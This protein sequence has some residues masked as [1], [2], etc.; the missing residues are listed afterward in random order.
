MKAKDLNISS[1][2]KFVGRIPHEKMASLLAQ[3]DVY[4]STSLSDGTS[5]SLL[6]AMGS[7]AFPVVTDIPANREWIINGENG[8]L[9]STSDESILTRKI[10][11]AIRNRRLLKEASR[12]NL[13]IIEQRADWKTNIGKIT[14]IYE[15]FSTTG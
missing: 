11:E 10:L 1:V 6:E 3:A 13:K 4:V 12:K 9:I 8:F 14:D 7:G 5:V 15:K 2:V